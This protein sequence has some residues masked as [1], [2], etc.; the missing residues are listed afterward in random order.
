MEIHLKIKR[1]KK[2]LE[3]LENQEKEVSENEWG[4]ENVTRVWFR[5][6]GGVCPSQLSARET[7]RSPEQKRRKHHYQQPQHHNTW[8]GSSR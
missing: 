4:G 7:P 5:S 1:S 2:E 8:A 6:K 3:A